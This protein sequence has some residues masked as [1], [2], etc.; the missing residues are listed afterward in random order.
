MAGGVV[1]VEELLRQH[2]LLAF[3]GLMI[4]LTGWPE[5]EDRRRFEAKI[6]G[7]GATYSGDLI[8]QVTHLIAAKPEGA[9]YTHAKQWGIKVVGLK[10]FEDSWKLGGG[11]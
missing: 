5:L 10:W 2:A 4:C 1:D 11:S 3:S 9:K 8:K 6:K 7:N